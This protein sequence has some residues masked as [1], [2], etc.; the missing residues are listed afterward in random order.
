MV[1][2]S[3]ALFV[4]LGGTG[5]AALGLPKNSVGN[6]QLKKGAVTSKK[7]KDHSLMAKDFESGQLPE[8]SQGP[9]GPQGNPGA[10][11][12]QGIQGPPG[13]STG[14]AGGDLTG[15]YP[16]PTIAPGVV[17]N[18]KLANSALAILPGAGL[19]GGG[20]IAL[21]DAGTLSVANGGIGTTQLG[22]GSVTTDKFA[23]TAQAP[24]SAQLG[25]LPAG[26]YAAVLSGRINGLA[27]TVTTSDYG[28]ASGISAANAAQGKVSTLSPNQTLMARGLS[29][30]VTS[31]PG[32]APSRD[33]LFTLMV[34]GSAT[35]LSCD[36]SGSGTTCSSGGGPV[37]V[38][39]GSTL[40]IQDTTGHL[41]AQPA[42]A[43]FGLRLTPS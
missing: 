15:S 39:P 9:P 14:P 22:Q 24:D 3:L 33:R 18:S 7:V 25:G 31:A 27:T 21:G 43:R 20:A 28:A 29:V 6:A 11:G 32:S 34:N 10:Q 37:S 2:A 19:A 30:Q 13:P 1:V 26:D 35:S 12:P 16:N 36:V 17:T 40:A 8:G 38:S 5:Y 4:A 42:D 41:G 23:P